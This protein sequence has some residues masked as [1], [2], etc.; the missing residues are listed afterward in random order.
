MKHT[1]KQVYRDYGIEF[2]GSHVMDPFGNWIMPLLTDGDDKIGKKAKAFSLYHGNEFVSADSFKNDKVKSVFEKTG[3][4]RIKG[5]CPFHCKECYCDSGHYIRYPGG[6]YAS[7]LYKL[8][9]VTKY[10]DFVKRAIT[11]QIIADDVKQCRIHEQGDFCTEN[12][13]EYIGVWEYVL[14]ETENAACKYWTYTKDED[15]LQILSKYSNLK[16]VP[17]ITPCGFNFGTC[18]ELLKMYNKLTAAGYRVHICACGTA[19]EGHCYDCNHGCK[20][21]GNECDYVLFIKHSSKEYKAG[22]NDMDDFVKV[23]EIIAKQ[24]AMGH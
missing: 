4:N 24:F 1:K 6:A 12:K 18:K 23:H 17:S 2:D 5:S 20:A 13:L 15:A 19:F 22:K 7:N 11:A 14:K 9:L 10:P 8:V 21:I 3:C 16:I